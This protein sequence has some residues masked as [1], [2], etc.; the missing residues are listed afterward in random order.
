MSKERKIFNYKITKM[1]NMNIK[2]IEYFRKNINKLK[3]KK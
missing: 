3:L 2:N 1:K